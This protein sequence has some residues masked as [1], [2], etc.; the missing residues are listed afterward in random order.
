MKQITGKD[1]IEFITKNKLED[2]IVTVTATVYHNG[3]HD[4]NTT[5]EVSISKSCKHLGYGKYVPT[6]DFYVDD[7]L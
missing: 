1:L 5:D 6:I 4:C 3:D 7:N 2:A